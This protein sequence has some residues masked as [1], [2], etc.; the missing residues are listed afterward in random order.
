[1]EQKIISNGKGR[2]EIETKDHE[3]QEDKHASRCEGN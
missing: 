3:R 1:M 2:Y